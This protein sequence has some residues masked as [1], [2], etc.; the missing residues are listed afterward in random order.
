MLQ[1][2]YSRVGNLEVI[3]CFPIPVDNFFAVA[4]STRTGVRANKTAGQKLTSKTAF[5]PIGGNER[6]NWGKL[7]K[8]AR[9]K[10]AGQK[11]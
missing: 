11:R 1:V 7:L 9:P 5:L 4:C 8:K 10:K 2:L 3:N 6:G